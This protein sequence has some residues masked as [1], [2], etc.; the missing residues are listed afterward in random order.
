[1]N[2]KSEKEKDMRKELKRVMLALFMA[3]ALAMPFPAT[4]AQSDWASFWKAFKT[5]VVRG[6]KQTVV[7]LSE[8]EQLPRAFPRL[9]GTRA[10]KRCFAK[11]RPVKDEQGGY[12]VF[13]GEQGYYFSKVGGQ[14]RFTDTFAND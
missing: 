5:A 7:R 9:F 4:A 6:D 13:C 14:F 3:T 1:L 12:S 10:Q 2:W 8:A 11:A